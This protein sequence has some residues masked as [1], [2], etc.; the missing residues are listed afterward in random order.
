MP[1]AKGVDFI[2]T[3]K[4]RIALIEVKNCLGDEGNCRWRIAPDNKKRETVRT[5]VDIDGRDSLD[6]EV[7]QKVAMT[8]A[9]L[10][11]A[12]L[13]GT[14]KSSLEELDPLLQFVFRDDFSADSKNAM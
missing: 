7:A 5:M 8:L 4:K 14:R 1:E 13:V 3:D 2:I 9:S 10:I 11:G 12:R 6:I